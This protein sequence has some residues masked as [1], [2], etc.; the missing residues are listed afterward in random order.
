MKKKE[1]TNEDLAL[2]VKKGFDDSATKGDVKGLSNRIDEL[3]TDL[4][5]RLDDIDNKLSNVAYDF[6]VKGLEK[7]VKKLELKLGLAGT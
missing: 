6:E 7:R 5:S 2:M 4:T 3:E 1:I